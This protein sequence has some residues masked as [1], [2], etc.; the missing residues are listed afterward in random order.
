M[1]TCMKSLQRETANYPSI[2]PPRKPIY[3]GDH[4]FH[5]QYVNHLCSHCGKRK[6]VYFADV[7]I[8]QSEPKEVENQVLRVHIQ[9]KICF[10]SPSGG[11]FTSPEIACA[12]KYFMVDLTIWRKVWWFW[13][14]SVLSQNCNWRRD[15]G[16]MPNSLSSEDH[17]LD[18]GKERENRNTD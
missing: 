12:P 10:A 6:L 11:P 15:N 2:S 8:F 3:G 14:H 18:V 7:T 5:W 16:A 9:R 1:S 17:L 4:Y 13:N